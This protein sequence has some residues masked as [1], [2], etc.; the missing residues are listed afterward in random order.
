MVHDEQGLT[1][2]LKAIL[3]ETGSFQVEKVS[4]PILAL[5]KFKAKFVILNS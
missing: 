5:S 4:D 3:D 1:F 2:T